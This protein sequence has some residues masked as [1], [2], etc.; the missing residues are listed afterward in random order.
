MKEIKIIIAP[1]AK[2]TIETSGFAGSSCADATKAFEEALGA[3]S[4]RDYK[5]EFYQSEE[6]QQQNTN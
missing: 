2:V 3:A 5:P 1:D 4:K 6:N